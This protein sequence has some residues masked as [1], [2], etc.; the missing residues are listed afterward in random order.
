[1]LHKL[2]HPEWT[3]RENYVSTPCLCIAVQEQRESYS[4]RFL[5]EGIQIFSVACMV[6]VCLCVLYVSAPEG[7][8]NHRIPAESAGT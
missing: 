2:E 1:M 3:N 6:C 5:L 7:I 8:I 4:K